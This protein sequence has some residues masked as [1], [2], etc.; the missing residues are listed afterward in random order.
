MTATENY[1]G[2]VEVQLE[3]KSDEPLTEISV[4]TASGVCIA[5]EKCIGY[6]HSF[7]IERISQNLLIVVVQTENGIYSQKVIVN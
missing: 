7:N 6:V 2:K 1:C 4:Y 3:M 5:Q